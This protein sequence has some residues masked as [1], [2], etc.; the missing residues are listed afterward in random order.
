MGPRWRGA[1][2]HEATG[3]FSS[4]WVLPDRKAAARVIVVL[5]GSWPG[6]V[7]LGAA[8]PAA[9]AASRILI[10]RVPC[11]EHIEERNDRQPQAPQRRAAIKP[12]RRLEGNRHHAPR[13]QS[14]D[15]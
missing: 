15:A 4:W 1:M 13:H 14:E 12:Q 9:A 5:I 3:K 10:G 11:V 8:F 7:R 2:S 6:E